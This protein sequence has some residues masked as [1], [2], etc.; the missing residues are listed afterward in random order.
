MKGRVWVIAAVVRLGSIQYDLVKDG[1]RSHWDTLP[2]DYWAGL[3]SEI[4]MNN[5][6][7]KFSV[8]VLV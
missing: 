7:L 1:F 2:S 4:K 6:K 3:K 8:T 5:L